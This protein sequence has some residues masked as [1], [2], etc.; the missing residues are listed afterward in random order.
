MH[1]L[2]KILVRLSPDLMSRD[3]DRKLLVE[4]ARG[5]AERETEVYQDRVFDWRE[6]EM[7][8]RWSSVYPENVILSRDN[9][10]AFVAELDEIMTLQ[11]E[12]AHQYLARIC[13]DITDLPTLV[14]SELD[15]PRSIDTYELHQ[16]ASL[17][18][19]EYDF[20]FR[21]FNC[22]A[23]T[24]R[25]EQATIDRVKETPNEWALV[26]FDYHF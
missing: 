5:V 9:L 6:T 3:C 21:F 12:I 4:E 14:Q 23:Y 10:D 24:A 19:G 11:H 16:L 15:S 22:D 7:A 2:H 20:F 1:A 18:H 13:K 25:I 26:M 17:L 8:G